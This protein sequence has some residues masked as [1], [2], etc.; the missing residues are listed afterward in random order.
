MNGIEMPL[1]F[2]AITQEALEFALYVHRP[3]GQIPSLSD[4]DSGSFV[5]LFEQGFALYGDQRYRWVATGG[6]EGIAPVERLKA[7]SNGGYYVLRSGWR[8]RNDRHLV[9]DCGPLGEGN[10]GH[11]DLLSF[12]L[13]GFGRPLIVDPGRYTYDESGDVNWRVAFRGTAFHNTVLV[14]GRNQTRYEFHRRKFKVRGPAPEFQLLGF[15]SRDGY[16]FV[17]GEA[18]SYEYD[19]VHRREIRMVEGGRLF[20]VLDWLRSPSVHHYEQRFHL[21]DASATR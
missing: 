8:D 5:E 20:V 10:H 12:E 4:G 21:V 6:K 15:G 17:C 18:A 16:D 14:D 7:F 3:D 11:F 9:F 2:D 19:V 13:Y 1:E